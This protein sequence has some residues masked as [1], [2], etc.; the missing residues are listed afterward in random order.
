[1][2]ELQRIGLMTMIAGLG[3][4]LLELCEEGGK[5]MA[6]DWMAASEEEKQELLDLAKKSLVEINK[7]AE[8]L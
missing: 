2:T 5:Q 7:L 3:E 6:S 1:M 4:N 8:Q